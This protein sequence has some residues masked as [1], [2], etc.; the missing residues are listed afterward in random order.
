MRFGL[1]E[2]CPLVERPVA[3][4]PLAEQAVLLRVAV[5]LFSGIWRLV[6][7]PHLVLGVSLQPY[8]GLAHVGGTLDHL[9]EL[10]GMTGT[11]AS[12]TGRGKLM[13]VLAQPSQ[14]ALLIG[15]ELR[16]CYVRHDRGE[17]GWAAGQVG[18]Q[19]PAGERAQDSRYAAPGHPE[20]RCQVGNGGMP[21]TSYQRTPAW[22]PP[23]VLT[24]TVWLSTI[25]WVPPPRLR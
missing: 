9:D 14:L 23:L 18:G 24:F 7:D 8:E 16:R 25:A 15:D 22:L 17:P 5:G 6:E 19:A 2:A 1:G 13:C 21:A 4:P 20:F 3:D 11:G 10:G 12:A